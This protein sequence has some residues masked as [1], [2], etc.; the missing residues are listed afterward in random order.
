MPGC[1]NY[2]MKLNEIVKNDDEIRKKYIQ[3]VK[4]YN[5][6]QKQIIDELFP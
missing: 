3:L 1:L 4:E 5:E 2:A 6:N